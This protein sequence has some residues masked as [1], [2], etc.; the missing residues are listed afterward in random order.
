VPLKTL[1]PTLENGSLEE[2]T[3][4]QE[5]WANMLANAVTMRS[6]IEPNYA[7]I[8]KD[9]SPLEVE[10]LVKLYEESNKEQDYQKKEIVAI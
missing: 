6:E 4:L 9:L 1:L 5:K 8:L 7:E 10:I 3:M 2:D